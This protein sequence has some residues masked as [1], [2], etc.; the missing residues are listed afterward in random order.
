MSDFGR[1]NFG[2][3][4]F[5]CGNFGRGFS[6][7]VSSFVFGRFSVV[8]GNVDFGCGRRVCK[9]V[10]GW[11][12]QRCD[13]SEAGG[14]ADFEKRSGQRWSHLTLLGKRQVGVCNRSGISLAKLDEKNL[15]KL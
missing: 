5:G 1:G 3:G 14:F 11:F 8:G 7:K 6:L 4:N 9:G 13:Q 2:C 12:A 15:Y 10:A